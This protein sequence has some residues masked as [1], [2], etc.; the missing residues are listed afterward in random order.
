MSGEE[1]A[2]QIQR[3]L[4]KN[5]SAEITDREL[6]DIKQELKQKAFGG[7]KAGEIQ[8]ELKTTDDV[9][10]KLKRKGKIKIG[11]YGI[12]RKLADA[13]DSQP[14]RD[15]VTQAE[16]SLIAIRWPVKHPELDSPMDNHGGYP[17][18]QPFPHPPPYDPRS[19]QHSSMGPPQHPVHHAAPHQQYP[20]Y[21][22][23]LMR[24]P[25]QPAPRASPSHQIPYQQGGI[26]PSHMAQPTNPQ[27][28]HQ[29]G[30]TGAP[31]QPAPQSYSPSVADGQSRAGSAT[32]GQYADGNIPFDCRTE[33]EPGRGFV[34]FINNFFIGKSDHRRGAEADEKNVRHLFENV[35]KGFHLQYEQDVPLR[36][37]KE[38]LKAL[39][40]TLSTGHYKSFIFILGSHGEPKDG[41]DRRMKDA[42]LMADG[43]WMLVEEIVS[44]FHGDQIPAMKNKPKVFII[45]SCRGKELQRS[46]S[47]SDSPAEMSNPGMMNYPQPAVT[48]RPVNSDILIAYATSEGMKAWRNE[49]EGSWFVKDLCDVITEYYDKEHILDI[50]VRVNSL[51][52][53]R[54]ATQDRGK[55]M[56]CFVCTFTRRF[57]L[58]YAK[59]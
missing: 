9:L 18:Q 52:V 29:G 50:L 49:E 25:T 15:Y 35:L 41:A 3:E 45:Q 32:S 54:E 51:M 17:P 31:Q 6:D 58:A 2:E 16:N 44:N 11:E 37:L 21:P 38:Y 23:S 56:P 47:L 28:S 13:I 33:Y 55:Q 42:V 57:K 12:L 10:E 46:V 22:D 5:I 20:N 4:F 19:Y 36:E 26:A 8:R 40:N 1:R 53:W 14:L 27:Y 34:L 39:K 59:K 43:D 7:F 30:W 48:T 24:P